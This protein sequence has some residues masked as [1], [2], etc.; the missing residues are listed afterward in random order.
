MCAGQALQGDDWR[1]LWWGLTF[2]SRAHL[3]IVDAKRWE[4]DPAAEDVLP[5]PVQD[6]GAKDSVAR[7]LV[8]KA[9]ERSA[10]PITP[11]R[12]PSDQNRSYR[13]AA[14]GFAAG[15]AATLAL[16]AA[17]ASLDLMPQAWRRPADTTRPDVALANARAHG[18][19]RSIL[20]IGGISPRGRAP[21]GI[22]AAVALQLAD[23]HLHGVDFPRDQGEASFWLRHALSLPLD[24]EAMRWS[25]TQLGAIH[26]APDGFE[27][28]YAKARVLWEL[29][30]T[31]G[32]P[33]A[34]CFQA[35]LYENGLGVPA[36]RALA[37]AWYERARFNGGCPD[38]DAALARIQ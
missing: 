30:S 26:A 38:L 27:P 16:I 5:V 13:R 11:P 24:V 31:F 8:A 20:A 15:I 9:I 7:G 21:A 17:A 35:T 37:R 10:A 1:G 33:I 18:T 2:V 29:A 12:P 14:Y 4:S 23:R 19:L 34:M 32:D 36:H 3:A 25:L 22:S 28:D 6:S